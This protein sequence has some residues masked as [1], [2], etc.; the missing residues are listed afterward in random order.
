MYQWCK[1]PIKTKFFILLTNP[2]NLKRNIK[3]LDSFF[4]NANTQTYMHSFTLF[5]K[6]IIFL[7]NTYSVGMVS[8]IRNISLEL[9]ENIQLTLTWVVEHVQA[10]SSNLYWQ[11]VSVSKHITASGYWVFMSWNED[12]IQLGH[13]KK[14]FYYV[15]SI[16]FDM[17]PVF[18][19]AFKF[20]KYHWSW[21]CRY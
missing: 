12:A 11:P 2:V 7:L 5:S 16:G 17:F 4:S 21:Q 10:S 14:G 3:I 19:C 9:L 20:Y 18:H 8:I 1:E 6:I 15:G 13:N